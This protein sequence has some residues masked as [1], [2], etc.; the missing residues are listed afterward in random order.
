LT[1]KVDLAIVGAG[2]GGSLMAMVA[3]K[4]GLSVVLLE[5]GLASSH[6]DWRIHYAAEQSF[7][8]EIQHERM[9]CPG[10]RR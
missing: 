4:L 6:G 8:G 1:H 2:F 7:A 10:W 5:Q 3:H 9:I